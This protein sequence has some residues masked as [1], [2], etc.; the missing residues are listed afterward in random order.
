M[1][2]EHLFDLAWIDVV[3]TADDE[4]LD[5]VDDAKVTVGVGLAEVSGAEPSVVGQDGGR[6]GRALPVAFMTVG[7]L[8][9][10]SPT[11]PAWQTFP[12]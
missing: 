5:A 12:S 9:N 3:S 4:V 11:V 7:P 10:T 2:V 1:L 8:M 6:V